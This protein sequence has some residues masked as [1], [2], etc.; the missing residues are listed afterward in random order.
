MKRVVNLIS[1]YD[2]NGFPP[3][4]CDPRCTVHRDLQRMD[5]SEHGRVLESRGR[6][7]IASFAS[8]RALKDSERMRRV[9]T[10]KERIPHIL[11]GSDQLSSTSSSNAD[12]T[13]S[14]LCAVV[15]QS[16]DE[17]H[18]SCV[19]EATR[20]K[21]CAKSGAV[22]VGKI[23]LTFLCLLSFLLGCMLPSVA[24]TVRLCVTGSVR[25]KRLA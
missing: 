2:V 4:P 10:R 25:A 12:T 8:D 5:P 3:V 7:D 1:T 20:R 6:L 22:H 21:L 14:P 15:E 13:C 11:S 9:V 16:V 17:C 24:D 19:S 23:E 18:P